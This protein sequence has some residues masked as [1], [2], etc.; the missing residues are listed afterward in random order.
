MRYRGFRIK[1]AYIQIDDTEQQHYVAA[2]LGHEHRV[3]FMHVNESNC[4]DMIDA[5]LDMP[6]PCMHIEAT[7]YEADP[8]AWGRFYYNLDSM[9]LP[10]GSMREAGDIYGFMRIAAVH[11]GHDAMSCC[12]ID[13]S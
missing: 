11:E 8:C 2:G 1:S 7:K 5:W 3:M 6:E 9:R 10:D 13:K 12:L 4:M